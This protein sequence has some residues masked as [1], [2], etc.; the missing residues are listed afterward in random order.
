MARDFAKGGG[1]PKRRPPARRRDHR[2]ESPG[3]IWRVYG[4]GVLTGIFLSFGVYV[5]TLPGPADPESAGKSSEA[6]AAQ[7]DVPVP[8]PRFDFYTLLPEQ[9]IDVEVEDPVGRATESGAARTA[10][11]T[12]YLLQA[13]SFRQREDADRRRA[14]LLLLGL[15]PMIEQTSA[16]SGRWHRV[17]LG[18]FESRAAMNRARALTA[19]ENID[20]LP[21][22][23]NRP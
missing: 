17:Y 5:A 11:G 19:A 20:T 14:E 16:G 2:R 3:R 6:A 12:R 1:S 13:G 10:A 23:R 7:A 22:K 9:T 4:A 21:L 15:D 18:P 8:E